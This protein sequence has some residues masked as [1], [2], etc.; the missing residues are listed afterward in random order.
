MLFFE[1]TQNN[2]FYLNRNWISLRG[3]RNIYSIRAWCRVLFWER[4]PFDIEENK[5]FVILLKVTG[6][7]YW[8]LKFFLICCYGYLFRKKLLFLFVWN[9]HN[10]FNFA[11]FQ[12]KINF[13]PLTLICYSQKGCLYRCSFSLS[14]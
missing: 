5:Y 14:F 6:I 9:F 4:F 10:K 2:W 8:L 7:V 12:T 11:N 1:I 3:K 13:A